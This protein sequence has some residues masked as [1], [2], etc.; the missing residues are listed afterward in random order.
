[1][2]APLALKCWASAGTIIVTYTDYA[3]FQNTGAR[4]TSGVDAGV[5][6]I[7]S[8]GAN[9]NGFEMFGTIDQVGGV[10][11]A[12]LV[13]PTDVSL[14]NSRINGCLILTGGGCGGPPGAN[15]TEEVIKANPTADANDTDPA[16]GGSA[17]GEGFSQQDLISSGEDEAFDFDSLVGTNN[18]GLLGVLGVDDQS[19]EEPCAPDDKRE[20]CKVKERANE[21]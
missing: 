10:G 6:Q 2:P 12:F 4:G 16:L 9:T 1:M 7:I 17:A 19:A 13:Q 21:Q 15:F 11:A 8:S 5:L 14:G 18:E 20:I 3:L